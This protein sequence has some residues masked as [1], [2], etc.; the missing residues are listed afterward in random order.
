MDILAPFLQK[1]LEGRIDHRSQEMIASHAQTYLAVLTV[2]Y[3]VHIVRSSYR[4]LVWQLL[5]FALSFTWSSVMMGLQ[6]FG[7]GLGLLLIATVIPWPY[8][9][10]HPVKFLPV[11][12]SHDL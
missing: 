8:L 2:S 7:Y 12:K 3:R 10:R 1:A 4:Y 9:Q 5:S 6:A 11:R